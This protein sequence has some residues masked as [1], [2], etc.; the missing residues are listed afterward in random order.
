M[1][2]RCPPSL[3]LEP[4]PSFL[5][6]SYLFYFFGVISGI[7]SSINWKLPS[8][9]AAAI[10]LIFDYPFFFSKYLP[11]ASTLWLCSPPLSSSSSSSDISLELA[12]SSL[13]SFDE[14]VLPKSLLSWLSSESHADFSSDVPS[15]GSV[16]AFYSFFYE[17]R[18]RFVYGSFTTF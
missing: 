10:I 5:V 1:D 11:F 12:S 7:G 9:R 4:N 15:S 17:I 14:S 3:S 13:E 8:W 18:N 6:K 2:E 16:T